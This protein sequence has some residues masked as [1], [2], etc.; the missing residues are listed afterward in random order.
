MVRGSLPST[1][2]KGQT[3]EALLPW[4]ACATGTSHEA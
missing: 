3:P 2:Q 4:K 1:L